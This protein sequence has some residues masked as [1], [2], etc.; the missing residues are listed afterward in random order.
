MTGLA[1]LN[2]P[3]SKPTIHHLGLRPVPVVHLVGQLVLPHLKARAHGG[4]FWNIM[5]T[6]RLT[7]EN[8]LAQTAASHYVFS[9]RL[10]FLWQ[11]IA[12]NKT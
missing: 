10:A 4:R 11:G 7:A 8:T 6:T 2:P 12:T 3:L 9:P 5:S 1:S